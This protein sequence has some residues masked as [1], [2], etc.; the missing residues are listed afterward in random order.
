MQKRIILKHLPCLILNS[1]TIVN[2]NDENK[3]IK[4]SKLFVRFS[5]Y[6]FANDIRITNNNKVIIHEEKLNSSQ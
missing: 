4:L 6:P 3:I 5:I 2:F 1:N